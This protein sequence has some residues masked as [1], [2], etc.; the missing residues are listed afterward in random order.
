[1]PHPNIRGVVASSSHL[2]VLARLD[3]KRESCGMF[4]PKW[5]KEAKLLAKGARKFVN[6]KRDLLKVD[7]VEEIES[8]R[9]DL[10]K[11]IKDGNEAKA[12]EAGKQLRATCENSL[13]YEK[14]VG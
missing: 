11:A 7:R 4:T 2:S 9:D 8:R 5:K 14:P 12:K 6:Y 3:S 10:L 1:M 13:K